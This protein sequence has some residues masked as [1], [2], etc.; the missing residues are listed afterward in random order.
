[1]NIYEWAEEYNYAADY[2]DHTTG[3]IYNVQEYGRVKRLHEK[4]NDPETFRIT[5]EVLDKGIEVYQDGHLIGY[6]KKTV[7]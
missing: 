5:Q 6:A 1:M 2:M 3:R 4:T 7:F